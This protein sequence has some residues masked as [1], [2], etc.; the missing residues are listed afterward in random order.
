MNDEVKQQLEIIDKQ[1]DVA[2]Q[3]GIEVQAIYCALEYMKENPMATPVEAFLL[4][5][6]KL[7]K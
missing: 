6:S 2:I 5:V 7:V 4:G 3:Y 1:L